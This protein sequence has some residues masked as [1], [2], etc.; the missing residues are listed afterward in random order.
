MPS[1]EAVR[2]SRGQITKYRIS[3]SDG[4]NYQGKRIR[5]R[6]IWKPPRKGMTEHQME[7]E[8]TAA[9]YKFEDDIKKGYSI[10][11]NQTFFEY[12]TYCLDLKKIAGVKTSTLERYESML[13]RIYEAIGHL[14][15]TDIRPHHLNDFYKKLGE[16][17][18]RADSKRATPKR[19]FNK[20]F[21]A[22]H[23]SKAAFARDAKVAAETVAT[24][25]KGNTIKV[26]KATAIAEAMGY[27]L[28]DLFDIKENLKPLSSKTIR[29]HHLLI[30][31][32]LSNAEKEMIVPYNA[33][34]KA[35][36]PRVQKHNPAYY[37]PA[38]M[39]EILEA[40]EDAPIRWKA[41]TY[42]LI[43]TGCRRGEIA[44]LR[45]DHVD[46][47]TNLIVIDTGLLY[48]PKVGI[49]ETATKTNDSRAMILAPQTVAVLKLWKEEY[50]RWKA[51]NGSR[52][53]NSPYVFVNEKGGPLHPDSIT[54]WLNRFS[55]EKVIPHLH[56]HAFRHTAA[57]TMIMNGIDVVSAAAELGHKSPSTTANI[58][59]HQF[60]IARAK[61]AAARGGVFSTRP[62]V[63]DKEESPAITDNST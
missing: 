21:A 19:I 15:L 34:A 51:A 20:R 36:P 12:A 2:N 52:W 61:A 45:W 11:T 4:S 39:D 46:L 38:E 55:E 8:A 42:L 27:S 49:Y 14:K 24:C 9:A 1:I 54:D 58:Y 23:T 62:F 40:L 29:E 13:P 47:R 5:H 31:S 57:S 60:S 30:S 63:N 3:V 32:I 7:R 25:L 37:S 43:D 53:E 50:D 41:L 18:M 48:S 44:G 10:G 56:P 33:A 17:G 35:S 16:S 22:L 26:E 28:G 6:T 59:A